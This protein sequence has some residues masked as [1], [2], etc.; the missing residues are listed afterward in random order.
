MND[1]EINHI[2]DKNKISV[3]LYHGPSEILSMQ[4]WEQLLAFKSNNIPV[5]LNTIKIP[6]HLKDEKF[7]GILIEDATVKKNQDV[8]N[9]RIDYKITLKGELV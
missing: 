2:K 5:P 1:H 3:I 6:D 9:N 4:L 8:I 7:T